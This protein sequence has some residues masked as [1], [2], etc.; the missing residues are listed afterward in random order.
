MQAGAVAVDLVYEPAETAWL[1][2]L[3]R[4]GVQTHNGLS[5]LVHQAAASFEMWTGTA[6]SV[7]TMRRAAEAAIA[8][9][10]QR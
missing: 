1:A 3:R 8:S 6:A 7:T 9:R 4:R 2:A 10:H 5:M